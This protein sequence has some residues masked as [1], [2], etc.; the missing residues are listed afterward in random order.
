MIE[1]IGEVIVSAGSGRGVG[2]GYYDPSTNQGYVLYGGN[3]IVETI[4]EAE[5]DLVRREG[6]IYFDPRDDRLAA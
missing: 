5:E 2:V 3:R 4:V 6:I 1:D